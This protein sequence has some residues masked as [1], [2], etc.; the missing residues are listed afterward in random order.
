MY[1][2][3]SLET[4]VLPGSLNRIRAGMISQC[5]NLKAIYSKA[6]EAPL[7]VGDGV[8]K[9][10]IAWDEKYDDITLYVP[11]GSRA[12]YAKAWPQFTS[13]V[14]M[15]VEA[16]QPPTKTLM[17]DMNGDGKRTLL[18]VVILVNRIMEER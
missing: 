14:E 5:P 8:S 18:D 2:C 4:I 12:S 3:E 16:M 10:L 6:H 15:D 7:I 17:G 11:K 1:G 9:Y 13:I